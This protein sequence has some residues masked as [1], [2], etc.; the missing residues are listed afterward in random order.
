M[1][2][3]GGNKHKAFVLI[4]ALLSAAII[5]IITIP[6]ISRVSTEYK[7]MHKI[8]SVT[9][10]L[11]LAEAAVERALWEGLWNNHLY[12]GYTKNGN[13]YT[14]SVNSFKTNTNQTIGD[15]DISATDDG[16]NVTVTGTGYVPNRANPTGK[17]MIR[18][19]S[20]RGFVKAVL[21]GSNI[22]VS[23]NPLIDTYNSSLG[24]YDSQAPHPTSG[25]DIAS[26]G[27][28]TFVKSSSSKPVKGNANPGP[29]HPMAT[30]P[31]PSGWVTGTYGTLSAPMTIDPIPQ[32]TLDGAKANNNNANIT[33][34]PR[35]P[36]WSPLSGYAL[37][38]GGDKQITLPAGT[39]YFT[40]MTVSNSGKIDISWAVVIYVEGGAI[41]VGGAVIINTGQPRNLQIYSS[42]TS[43][44]D[45][46]SADLV[47]SVYAPNASVSIT[48]N[49]DFYGAII[50]GSDTLSN[51]GKIHYDSDL[52]NI[53]PAFKNNKTYTWQEIQH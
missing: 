15:Y 24:T 36:T 51:S 19:V 44:T 42:G 9:A 10:A 18:V 1:T 49:A 13:V 43:I 37:T 5:L 41:S 4:T 27:T 34:D 11:D 17:R 35:Y 46:N 23:G 45:S 28:I 40:S 3:H 25:A 53:S 50:S 30:S 26:N 20:N 8:Y 14:L 31:D 39:Y 32:A 29:G 16:M 21:S 33:L 47:A 22:T 12:T 7:L 6:Y 48:G 38:V 2:S 52:Q